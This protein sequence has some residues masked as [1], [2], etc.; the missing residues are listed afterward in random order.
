MTTVEILKAA[1]AL[2]STPDKWVKGVYARND[3]GVSVPD[4]DPAACAFCAVGAMRHACK[5]AEHELDTRAS[6]PYFLAKRAVRAQT[7]HGAVSDFN[8][9]EETTHADVLA[10]FDRAIA[11]YES[12]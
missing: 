6:D 1:R 11:A 10:A 7:N 3:K 8:D 4:N 9:D 12:P 2:I 5:I